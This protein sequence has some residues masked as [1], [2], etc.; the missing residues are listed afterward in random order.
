MELVSFFKIVHTLS[1]L[2][3]GNEFTNDSP[4]VSYSLP[5]RLYRARFVSL[6]IEL[7]S[8]SLDHKLK[9]CL[10]TAIDLTS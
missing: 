4:H 2:R 7:S 10:V 6:F 5:I 3:D 8:R 9:T 1:V